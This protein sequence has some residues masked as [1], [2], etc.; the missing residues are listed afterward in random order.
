[1]IGA[2]DV[3]VAIKDIL[4]TGSI[5][6]GRIFDAE[7]NIAP[8]VRFPYT[9]IGE[10]QILGAD[11]IGYQGSDE[12][13]PLHIWDRA[14]AEGGQRGVKQVKQIGDQIHGLLN[15]KNIVVNGRSAAFVAMRD[16]RI[17]PDPDPLTAHGLLTFRIQHFGE[18]EL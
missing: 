15:G 2:W 9:T 11:A 8:D 18:K 3:Q 16:F 10:S 4:A 14:N 13:L 17:V 5:T 6:E 7:S 1:M 12:F